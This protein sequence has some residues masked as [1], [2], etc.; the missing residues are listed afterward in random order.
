MMCDRFFTSRLALWAGA[1]FA[2]AACSGNALPSLT[3]RTPAEPAARAAHKVAV[4]V[5][6]FIPRRHE[7]DRH[8]LRPYFVANSTR[9]IAVIVY[10]HGGTTPANTTNASV[11]ATSPLCH[12]VT[13]GRSC[14]IAAAAPV[15]NDDFVV[16]TYD[17]APSGGGFGSA[18]QLAI[19]KVTKTIATGK[20]N[21]L[22]V[23]VGG[24]VAKGAV[25]LS[26]PVNPV[27]DKD[28]QTVTVSALD[29]D[30]NTIVNDGWYDADGNAVS[31]ALAASN[32]TTPSTFVLA[33]TTATFA[34]STASLTYDS[35]TVTSSQVQNGFT[36]NVSATPSN[37]GTAG[38]ATFTLSKP[39]FTEFNTSGSSTFPEGIEVGPDNAIWFAENAGNAIGRLT[40]NAAAGSSATEYSTG[41]TGGASPRWLANGPDGLIWFTEFGNY[42]VASIDPANPT[43]AVKEYHTPSTGSQPYGIVQG[44]DGNMWFAENCS[45]HSNIGKFNAAALDGSVGTISEIATHTAN[46]TPQMI[47]TGTDNALWFTETAGSVNKIGRITTGSSPTATDYAVTPTN[48]IY[49]GGITEGPD[50]A[51]WFAECNGAG[52]AIGRITLTGTVTNQVG[53]S[54]ASSDPVGIVTGPDGA[55]W[56]TENGHNAI[57]RID[58]TTHTIIEFTVPTTSGD[59]WGIVKGPDG[60]LWFTEND[61]GKI[62]KL[63]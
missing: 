42:A 53:L 33:P 18:N 38:G 60:A 49:Q 55:L 35:T 29:A 26:W 7:R 13:G 17:A 48:T 12:A 57:G 62:G 21:S 9:G 39:A 23:T 37:G 61:K 32:G 51:L 3:G 59:P 11:G 28:V 45:A 41:M 22:N 24:V 20:A 16:K 63:Q 6:V 31:F 27:I 43:A 50:G 10:L 2:L 44:P 8:R 58:P 40:T 56:F 19:G 36:S 4:P 47:T 1:G 30:G 25:N 54:T 34:A 15:A 5:R 46:S 14:T 52:N